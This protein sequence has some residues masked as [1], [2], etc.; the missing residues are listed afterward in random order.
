MAGADRAGIQ[1]HPRAGG[2]RAGV[3]DG[4]LV[5]ELDVIDHL[6]AHHVR[7]ALAH[8]R[9]G[10]DD[11]VR[12]DALEDAAVALG[13]RLGPD[14]AD[15]E[16]DQRHGGEQACLHVG[17]DADHR[18]AAIAD[19]EALQRGG[20]GGVGLD[21]LRQAA[22]HLLHELGRLVDAEHLVAH[23]HERLRHRA[24]EAAQSD[25]DDG[26]RIPSQ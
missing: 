8:P 26:F 10:I 13:D 5:V 6:A 20:I 17:A 18:R 25:D 4:E 7:D 19:A 9:F 21:D 3:G 1:R 12:A 24:A 15:A 22:C 2:G 23:A 14:R 16:V 11:M